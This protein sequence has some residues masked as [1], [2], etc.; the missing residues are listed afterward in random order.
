VPVPPMGSL[1]WCQGS[2]PQSVVVLMPAQG[3]AEGLIHKV[4]LLKGELVEERQAWDVA[5]ERVHRMLNSS[6]EGV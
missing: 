5:G 4:A 2:R 6:V 1:C 3:D